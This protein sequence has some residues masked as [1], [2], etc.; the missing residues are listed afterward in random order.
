MTPRHIL[1]IAHR[2]I[3][4][5][6][7][8][9]PRLL[10]A[11]QE[12]IP[13]TPTPK[14]AAPSIIPS[15]PNDRIYLEYQVEKPVS[16]A[17]AEQPT[18]PEDLRRAGVQGSVTVQFVVDT[19]GRADMRSFKVIT[20]TYELFDDAVRDAVSRSRYQAAELEHRK[21]KQLVQQEFNFSLKPAV[22][23]ATPRPPAPL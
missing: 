13:K 23:P 2:L 11:Q 21:V 5:S 19:S 9:C 22:P 16:V 18:Y 15:T 20:S 10:L 17:T 6:I 8:L 12:H 14:P 3:A 1:S 7:V 4:L